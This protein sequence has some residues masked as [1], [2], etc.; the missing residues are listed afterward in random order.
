M[1]KHLPMSDFVGYMSDL[2]DAINEENMQ[3][4]YLS[5]PFQE[6]SYEDYK[7]RVMASTRPK[8]TV[9]KEANEKANAIMDKFKNMGWEVS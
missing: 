8:Q 1:L 2:V 3:R 6:E 9:E 5:N 4:V 7:A